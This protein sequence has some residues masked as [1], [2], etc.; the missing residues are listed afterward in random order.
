MNALLVLP[1]VT[2]NKNQILP[3][4]IK[5]S[6]ELR[7]IRPSNSSEMGSLWNCQAGRAGKESGG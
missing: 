2:M 1:Q 7:S 6:W 5:K 4:N 3:N